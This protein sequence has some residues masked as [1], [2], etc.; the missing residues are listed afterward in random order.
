ML[1]S[2]T[3][4]ISVLKLTT[5]DVILF[6]AWLHLFSKHLFSIEK[7]KKQIARLA[8]QN[9]LLTLVKFFSREKTMYCLFPFAWQQFGGKLELSMNAAFVPIT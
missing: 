4:S 5:A 9:Q 6:P 3:T 1:T 7:K 8:Q 2:S